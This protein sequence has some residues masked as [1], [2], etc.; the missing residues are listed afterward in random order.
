[1]ISVNDLR[2]GITFEEG[3]NIFKVLSFEHIK[4]GRGSA[5][6]KV[7]VKN[8]RSGATTEKGY[9]NGAFVKDIELQK[10]EFQFLYKEE[11]SA[12]F[13]DPVTFEQKQVPLKTL[14]GKKFLKEGE[15]VS[16]EFY[17]DE[18]L[19]LILPPKITLKVVD[20][21]PG[22]KGNSASNVYKDAQL[23]NGMNVRVPLFVNIGEK[24]VV[25]TREGNYTKRA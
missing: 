11:Q 3:E 25:D 5:N 2:A 24:I 4:M 1:M 20:T 6:I 21:T 13:M 16:L 17:Q 15:V 14:T 7:K 8:L 9:T 22:V 18:A 10:K 12:Y 23:E 19:D